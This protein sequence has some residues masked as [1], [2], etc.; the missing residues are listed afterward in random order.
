MSENECAPVDVCRSNK[1]TIQHCDLVLIR[2]TCGIYSIRK[3]IRALPPLA[4]GN[5]KLMYR[6]VQK[7]TVNLHSTRENTNN[8]GSQTTRTLLQWSTEFKH[9]LANMHLSVSKYVHGGS[10]AHSMSLSALSSQQVFFGRD[11]GQINSQ[12]VAPNL[13]GNDVTFAAKL[14]QTTCW[15]ELTPVLSLEINF[16]PHLEGTGQKQG[17]QWHELRYSME[18]QAACFPPSGVSVAAGCVAS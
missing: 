1:V 15:E 14:H 7:E 13:V 3:S 11:V 2:Q 12:S 8:Y 16:L 9:R 5:I 17:F 10:V 18:V 4:A 6:K